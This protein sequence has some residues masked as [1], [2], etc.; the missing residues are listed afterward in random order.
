MPACYCPLR[1]WNKLILLLKAKKALSSMPSRVCIVWQNLSSA[2]EKKT[3][4]NV[5]ETSSGAMSITT[6]WYNLAV[7][8][9]DGHIIVSSTTGTLNVCE[10]WIGRSAYINWGCDF[11]W[12]ALAR[13]GFFL[14]VEK[15][16]FAADFKTSLVEPRAPPQDCAIWF[17][18]VLQPL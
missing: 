14:S 6:I 1:D 11:I 5:L 16:L 7:L 12:W 4:L 15:G 2:F 8:T 9:L 17:R 3:F 13:K 10:E 18:K